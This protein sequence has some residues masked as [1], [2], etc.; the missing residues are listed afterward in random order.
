[1]VPK[2]APGSNPV[3]GYTFSVIRPLLS[4]LD[5]GLRFYPYSYIFFYLDLPLA[6]SIG[7]KI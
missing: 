2:K 7:P 3:L 5:L 6:H 4:K 1:M